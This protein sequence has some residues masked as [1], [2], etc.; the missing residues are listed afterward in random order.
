MGR[1]RVF[2]VTE[3]RLEDQAREIRPKNGLQK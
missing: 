3:Q 1:N 2:P